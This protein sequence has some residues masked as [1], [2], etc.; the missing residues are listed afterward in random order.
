MVVAA[1]ISKPL[2]KLQV[3]FLKTRCPI[4]MIFCGP[5]P[6]SGQIYIFNRMHRTLGRTSAI[7]TTWSNIF[8]IKR[9]SLSLARSLTPLMRGG[10]ENRLGLEMLIS[11]CTVL[12][13]S[14]R[15]RLKAGIAAKA[16][17]R[18]A[19]LIYQTLTLSLRPRQ[20]MVANRHRTPH[21]TV[22]QMPRC[23]KGKILRGW[24]VLSTRRIEADQAKGRLS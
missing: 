5:T 20:R 12:E 11:W 16:P 19:M 9:V 18:P 22:F 3:T 1:P 6:S 14:F 17:F 24:S 23:P 15:I 13:A 21:N 7:Y 4:R 8:K 10:L 2:T